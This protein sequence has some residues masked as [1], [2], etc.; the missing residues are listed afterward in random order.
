[1]LAAKLLFIAVF[2]NLPL[3]VCHSAIFLAVGMPLS[4][5]FAALLWR[6]VFFT[7]F[8]VLPAAALASI[9][10]SIGRIVAVALL[11]GGGVWLFRGALLLLAR[12]PMILQ[13]G[14]NR[15]AVVGAALLVA[16]GS[17]ILVLQY[18][19]RKTQLAA[20]IAVA[21]AIALLLPAFFG[22][23]PGI[24]SSAGSQPTLLLDLD[25]E[26]RAGVVPE[27]DPDLVTLEFPVRLNSV[28]E[29][30]L[31]DRARIPAIRIE[32]AG[33]PRRV[34]RVTEGQLHDLDAGRAWLSVFADSTLLL[35][36][37]RRQVEV[38][39]S[40]Q[41]RLFCSPRVLPVP[42]GH[43]VTVPAVG[44]CH[45]FLEPGGWIAFSCYSASP[46]AAL[47][48][49]TPGVRVN[50]IVPPGFASRSIPTASGFQP[51]TRFVSL[52]SYRD[53]EQVGMAKLVAAEPLPPWRVDIRLTGVHLPAYS[54]ARSN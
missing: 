8:C 29:G 40:F 30:V 4:G 46:H 21:L 41:L 23:V 33:S 1:M 24:R 42:K 12:R 45:N 39:G 34:L 50:W 5:Q 47:L 52:L 14:T 32:A 44:V 36:A 26:R 25:P 3:L 38:S 37:Q 18:A 49:G 6:Q 54:A 7:A 15:A 22:P 48:V 51:L 10:R 28:P 35:G 53:W 9:T 11:S 16:G 13:Q 31:L 19:R 27:V 43:A 20:G 17:T 2:V